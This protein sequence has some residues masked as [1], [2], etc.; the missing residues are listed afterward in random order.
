MDAIDVNI[1]NCLRKNARANASEI[2]ETVSLS[3]SA[4]IERIKKLESN[5]VILQYSAVLDPKLIGQD[6]IAF[7]SIALDHAKDSE[8]FV[9]A[10]GKM[11][12]VAECYYVSGDF[13]FHLKICAESIT[14]L[15]KALNDIKSIRG[16]SRTRT[17]ISFSTVKNDCFSEIQIE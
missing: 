16:V 3:V 5:G 17:M 2:A 6:V 1:L 8:S 10:I 7:I 9:E 14:C 13:D 15:E 4:V 12:A 11:S